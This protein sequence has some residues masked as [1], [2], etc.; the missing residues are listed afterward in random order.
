MK[1]IAKEI[2]SGKLS[3]DEITEDTISERLYT[4]GIEDPDLLIRTG[5]EMR[6]SNYLLWQI[7]YSEFYVTEAFW[8]D[9][10]ENDLLLAVQ[11]F[12]KRERRFG[13]N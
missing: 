2:Q 1:D 6:I 10:G 12:A 7:A 11:A 8:P 13:K 4:K 5:G 9:F 3:P